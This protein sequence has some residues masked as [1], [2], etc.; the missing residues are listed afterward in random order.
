M[1]NYFNEIKR[2]LENRKVRK[3]IALIIGLAVIFWFAGLFLTP[4]HYR[5]IRLPDDAYASQYLTNYILPQL[6]NK[7]QYNQPFELVISETGINDIIVRHIDANSLR[8]FNLSNL[9][10]AFTKGRVLLTGKTVYCGLDFIVTIILKPYISREG[11][12]FLKVP[13]IQAGRSRIPFI[14]GTVKRKILQELT[15]FL[16]NLDIADSAMTVFDG[17]KIEP[18]FSINHQKLRIDKISIQNKELLIHFL[19]QQDK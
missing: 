18:V 10:I 6:L 5:I 1:E 13:E 19:P 2:L 12:F 8:Q 17:R 4:A 7:S 9:N 3:A 16:N 14:V 11:Y 15:D